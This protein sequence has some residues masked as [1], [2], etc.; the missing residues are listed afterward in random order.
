[1]RC[2]LGLPR[3]SAA[4]RIARG[5]LSTSFGAALRPDELDDAKLVVSELVSNAL[6]HG[7][8]QIHLVADLDEDRLRIEVVDEG[9][10][11]AHTAREVPFNQTRGR[12]LLIVDTIAAR[13]GIFEHTTHVWAEIERAGPRVGTEAEPARP[14]E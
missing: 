13:W 5:A 6:E 12:G 1:M 14:N 7:V 10:G 3:D 2:E 8:G 4:P 9:T 11:F